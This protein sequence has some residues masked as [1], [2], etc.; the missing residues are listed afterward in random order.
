M[1]SQLAPNKF[2]SWSQGID[3][4][5]CRAEV[6]HYFVSAIASAQVLPMRCKAKLHP[7]LTLKVEVLE[8]VTALE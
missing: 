5:P 4:A 2:A 6:S 1:T 8:R 7:A 3:I